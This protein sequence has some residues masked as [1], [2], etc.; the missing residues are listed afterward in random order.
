M[1]GL[2]ASPGQLALER[3]LAGLIAQRSVLADAIANVNTPGYNPNQD[4][5]FAVALQTAVEAQLGAGPALPAP[6]SGGLTAA[7]AIQLAAT[8]TALQ[9]AGSAA[10]ALP[11]VPAAGTVSPD[12]NGVSLDAAM[13]SLAQ[14]DLS[15][16]AAARQLQLIYQNIGTAI[17]SGGA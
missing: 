17:D 11:S 8:P 6:A 10:P 13:I 2:F 14:S 16:Q 9:G 4:G 7:P 12:G 15:Y 3:Q 1:G 5:S